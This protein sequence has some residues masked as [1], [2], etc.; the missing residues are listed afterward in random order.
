MQVEHHPLSIEFPE[1][2]DQIHALKLSDQ[3]F[4]KLF[5]AY[6]EADKAVNRAENGQDNLGDA[7]LEDLKKERVILKDELYELLKAA[8]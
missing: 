6:S 3:H 1:F 2:K 4:A 8:A 5:D 7:E